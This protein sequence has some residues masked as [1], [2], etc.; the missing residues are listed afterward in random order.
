[1]ETRNRLLPVAAAALCV[2]SAAPAFAHSSAGA[3]ARLTARLMTALA[4]IVPGERTLVIDPGVDPATVVT[5][6]P[7]HRNWRLTLDDALA[8]AKLAVLVNPMTGTLRVFPAFTSASPATGN[9]ISAAPAQPVHGSEAGG[10]GPSPAVAGA[11]PAHPSV[12]GPPAGGT[13]PES[14][15]IPVTG[16]WGARIATGRAD[17]FLV[18]VGLIAPVGTGINLAAPPP[19][20]AAY[21]WPAARRAAALRALLAGSGLAA[22]LCD[23]TL[24]IAR[25][26]A[27]CVPC[28]V[29]P[30]T[31]AALPMKA[32][33]AARSTAKAPDPASS[34]PR[35]EV[36]SITRGESMEAALSKWARRANWHIEWYADDWRAPVAVHITAKSFL[37]AAHEWTQSAVSNG[38][39]IRVEAR[40]GNRVLVV[41]STVRNQNGF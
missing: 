14:E 9:S 38:A 25:A 31:K 20:R 12:S 16:P 39:P 40:T 23:G 37:Q 5:W 30:T 2:A 4:R 36:W 19:T 17:N 29:P 7:R 18:A 13:G 41:E 11:I 3:P 21:A 6:R 34:P 1:M 35:F 27:P 8:D 32:A 26:S 24:Y 22:H 33:T 10:G 15:A 28:R